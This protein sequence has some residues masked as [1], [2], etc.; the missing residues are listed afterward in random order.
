MGNLAFAMAAKE[1]WAVVIIQGGKLIYEHSPNKDDGP[2]KTP[3]YFWQRASLGWS[4][5]W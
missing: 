2:G 1:A 5:S 3:S 4:A